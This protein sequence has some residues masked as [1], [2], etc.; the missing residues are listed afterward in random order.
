MS[1]VH[2]GATPARLVPGE[3]D[4]VERLAARL[5]RF[6]AGAADASARL[7][8][9]DAEHWSGEAADLFRQA[10]GPVPRQ[11]AGAGAAFAAAARALTAYARALREAQ[12]TAARAIRL[13]AESTP[14]TA[15][16]DREAARTMVERARGD[17]DE[18]GRAA[19]ARLSELAADAPAAAGTTGGAG[20]VRSG[21]VEIRAA[22]AHDLA[23][24]EGFVA[25]AE[26]SD[27]VRFGADHAVG[28]AVGVT[29]AESGQPADW[30]QWTAAG[31]GRELGA[32]D[33]GVLAGLGIGA[34]GATAMIGRRRRQ[35]TALAAAGLD[36]AA[37][38][39]RRDRLADPPR[40][41]GS[42]GRTRS[43]RPR[44]AESWRTRLASPP[45]DGATVHVWAGSEATPLARTR[46]AEP[47]TLVPSGAEVTGAVQRHGK[48][49]EG[50]VPTATR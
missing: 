25:P 43:G 38:R 39:A 15:V 36:E 3:P 29:G 7:S 20:V 49:D 42:A 4:E 33:A 46:G 45:R 11:L 10:A 1:E 9:L 41:D 12:S 40:G 35:Q 44:S 34:I 23:D 14:D 17:V 32:V 47:V 24:P 19:A 27:G 26:V 31:E 48:S 50:D 30:T 16:T 22:V 18:A 5:A 8:R 2:P 6:A 21:G 28:F 13:V 37:L